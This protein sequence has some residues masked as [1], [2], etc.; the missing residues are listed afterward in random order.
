MS[1]TKTP[2]QKNKKNNAVLVAFL[3]V[4]VILIGMIALAFNFNSSPSGESVAVN[5]TMQ[6]TSISNV[7]AVNSIITVETKPT[8]TGTSVPSSKLKVGFDG[9]YYETMANSQ[10]EWEVKT[11]K[12]VLPGVYD[13][14][15]ETYDDSGSLVAS[16]AT[17][18]E[19]KVI[20]KASIINS[21][22]QLTQS[23]EAPELKNTLA[24]AEFQSAS[25]STNSSLNSASNSADSVT[26]NRGDSNVLV[27]SSLGIYGAL[28][29]ST[30]SS[31]SSA[32]ASSI[33]KSVATSSTDSNLARTGGID[34]KIVALS[35]VFVVFNIIALLAVKQNTKTAR[36]D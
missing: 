36:L 11:T 5:Q 9:I 6:T 32:S 13:V 35:L 3:A 12:D 29:D 33:S 26:N 20:A 2:E 8:I 18:D 21:S 15:L 22:T 4:D 23:S 25:F 14:R 27:S 19:I 34:T 30:A 1:D 17:I 24:L 16:D 31:K 28:A 7:P 10:G